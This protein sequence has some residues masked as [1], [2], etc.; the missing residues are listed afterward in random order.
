MNYIESSWNGFRR[1]DFEFENRKTILICP[2]SS[3]EGKKWLLKTEYFDAFPSFEIEMLKRGY[4]LVYITNVTRWHIKADS[5][6][7]NRLAGFLQEKFG[8]NSKCMPVG[9]S[10]GGLQAVYF[11]SLYPE[12]VAAMY[13]DAPVMNLL[14]CPCHIG[15][16]EDGTMYDEFVKATGY[17]VVDMINYRNHPIDCI[18]PIIDNKIPVF[19]IAGDSDTVVPFKE[20][21]AVLYEKMAAAGADITKIVKQG[22]NHH[23]HGLDDNTPLIEFTLK[24]Y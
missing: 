18:Q 24:N 17:T 22:C 7:K 9:M 11:A 2:N 23:P 13:L 1:L 6:A 21:G 5:D 4:H 16:S 15:L 14:S 3:C 8:L 10:C 19:L 20:N 12:R